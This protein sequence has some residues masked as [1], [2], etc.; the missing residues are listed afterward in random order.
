MMSS[1]ISLDPPRKD[2][3]WHRSVQCTSINRHGE[4]C[5]H[6][7]IAGG[8]VCH[9]HGG[10]TPDVIATAK[11]RLLAM[12]EPAFDVLDRATRSAPKCDKC[13]RSDSDRDPVALAA[14]K[15]ILDR[16]GFGKHS[17]ITVEHQ[18]EQRPSLFEW[19]TPEE[20]MA[21]RMAM[22]AARM[23]QKSGTQPPATIEGEVVQPIQ[24][25]VP[26]A[27]DD[28]VHERDPGPARGAEVHTAPVVSRTPAPNPAPGTMTPD[29]V[30]RLKKRVAKY[31]ARVARLEAQMAAEQAQEK[32]QG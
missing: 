25:N 4:R 3:P 1:S 5:G 9:L 11:R 14:A 30:E 22:A 6:A 18:A 24:S 17:K 7:A 32:S 2:R 31:A 29:Q 27:S 8:N 20:R 15:T 12:V 10:G 28:V 21:V 23:R 16:A 26:R 19:M 13:G